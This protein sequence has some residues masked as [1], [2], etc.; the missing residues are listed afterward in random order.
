MTCSDNL[1]RKDLK[2]FLQ[3]TVNAHQKGA[4]GGRDKLWEFFKDVSQDIL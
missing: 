4:F 1:L 3:N 2:F